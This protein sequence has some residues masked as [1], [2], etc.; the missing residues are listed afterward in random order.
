MFVSKRNLFFKSKENGY[1]LFC[2]NSNSFYQVDEEN[3]PHVQKMFDTGDDSE[4][5]E[6]IKKEFIKSGV[7]L[8]E[9]DEERFK[10][11][12]FISYQ[13]RFNPYV[14]TLT[15]APT[16]AC[17]FKCVYCFEGDRVQNVTMSEEVVDGL[18]EFIKKHNCKTLNLN[19]YGGEPLCAWDKLMTINERIKELGIPNIHQ[20]MVTNGSML[21]EE[22]L[23]YLIQNDLKWMQI[24]LDGDEET[25]NLRR[26]MKNGGSSYKAVMSSLDLIYNYCKE[27]KSKLK[28]SVRINVDKTNIQLYESIYKELNQKYNYF[29]YMHPGIVN[30][31]SEQDCH[32]DACL[33]SQEASSFILSLL[34]NYNIKAHEAYPLRNMLASC[35]VNCV[36]TYVICSNGD[37]YRCWEDIG[38]IDKKIGNITKGINDVRNIISKEVMESSGFED[39]K[40]QDCLFLYSCMGGCPKKRMINKQLGKELNPVCLSIKNNTE[41]YL[42]S[43]YRY[44]TRNNDLRCKSKE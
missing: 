26:P 32:A 18:I 25:H 9:S 14:L 19:W 44:K 11:L 31:N 20:T 13:T 12:K 23:S 17:N 37:I 40:C 41:E 39:K 38:I 5:P 24:T 15:V 1:L 2:G 30:K 36:N 28:V 34:N 3:V 22:K 10:R 7:L 6:D 27:K 35:S 29:F 43:Y 16:M 4:L 42:E 33:N 21:D 8:P